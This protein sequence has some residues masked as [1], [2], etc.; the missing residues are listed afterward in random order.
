MSRLGTETAFEVLNKARLV[1]ARTTDDP[2]V[3]RIADQAHDGI[4]VT[5]PGGHV[6]YF[7]AAYLALTGATS[8]LLEPTKAPAPISVLYLKKPS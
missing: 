5:D 7:N 4:A 2:V 6:V 1:D 3:R 8:A